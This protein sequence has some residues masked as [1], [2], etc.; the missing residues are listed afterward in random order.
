MKILLLGS[1]GQV[2]RELLRTLPRLGSLTALDLPEVDL[3]RPDTLPGLLRRQ[4][5]DVVVNAA[6]YTAV[7]RAETE[8]AL[9]E[10]VNADAVAVLAAEAARLDAIFVHY[11]T[12][13]VFDGAKPGCY[14]ETDE[15]A[16]LGVYGATK[17]AGDRAIAAAGGRHLVFRTSWV[18][19]A[20]GRN[21]VRSIQIGR[22]HV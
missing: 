15:P 13:Y 16:P 5:P 11:S 10:I 8:P 18:Y 17:L 1:H 4:R 7:D 21:F 3:S 14:A 22:A 2:G 9:A 6:A 20:H 19:A 12:D